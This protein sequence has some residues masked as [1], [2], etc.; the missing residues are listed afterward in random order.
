MLASNQFIRLIIGRLKDFI[1]SG[2]QW[3]HCTLVTSKL[4]VKSNKPI[5]RI[6]WISIRFFIYKRSVFHEL[7]FKTI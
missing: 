7:Y 2:F 5:D 6:D 1:R 4:S 3:D